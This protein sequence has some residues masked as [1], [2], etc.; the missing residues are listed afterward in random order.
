[1]YHYVSFHLC[2]LFLYVAVLCNHEPL[3]LDDSIV[4]YGTCYDISTGVDLKIRAVALVGNT[5][6]FLGE[7]DS[8]GKFN[9]NVPT[10]TKYIL[11]SSDNY[12]S[13]TVQANIFVKSNKSLNYRISVPMSIKESLEVNP[14][15]QLSLSFSTTNETDVNYKLK[16]INSANKGVFFSFRKGKQPNS[17]LINNIAFGDYVLEAYNTNGSLLYNEEV[18]V[19]Q[20]ITFKEVSFTNRVSI[21]SDGK[22]KTHYKKNKV[23][24]VDDTHLKNP[25][26]NTSITSKLANPI[27]LHFSQSSYELTS[28]ATMILDS[29]YFHLINNKKIAV[30]IVGYT[31]NIGSRDLNLALSEYRARIATGYLTGKGVEP[32]RISFTGKGP[33][34]LLI[35]NNT[36]ENKVKSR[37]VVITFYSK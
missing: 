6:L 4:V 23:F 30:N 22:L 9:F 21:T 20:G 5:R 34:P 12:K 29:I 18:N 35:E 10:N 13:I 19:D 11:F 17:F 28:E 1:M 16:Y 24:I 15:N 7:S 26:V 8:L 14:L 27:V 37:K 2:T 33:D 3:D 32:T 25:S 31:D 36:E